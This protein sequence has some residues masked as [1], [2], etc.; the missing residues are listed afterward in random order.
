MSA[1]NHSVAVYWTNDPT[2]T[3]QV[4]Y[5]LKTPCLLECRPP[6]GPDQSIAPGASF[7]TFR[8]FELASDSTERERRGLELRRMYRALAPW[9]TENP[10]LMH[11]T[12]S[13]PEDVKLAIDQCA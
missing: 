13:K 7:A 5:N 6:I 8:V 4:N 3:T 12:S 9:I 1:P 11:V 2:Y 10:I